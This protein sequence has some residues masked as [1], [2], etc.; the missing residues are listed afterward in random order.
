VWRMPTIKVQIQSADENLKNFCRI[1]A[2]PQCRVKWATYSYVSPEESSPKELRD[3]SSSDFTIVGE[4]EEYRLVWLVDFFE[5]LK[6]STMGQELIVQGIAYKDWR[7][8]G[9]ENEGFEL[10]KSGKADFIL[11]YVKSGR[12]S[13]G[14]PWGYI[15]WFCKYNKEKRHCITSENAPRAEVY[16]LS[17]NEVRVEFKLLVF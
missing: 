13:E 12:I 3:L 8:I 6:R 11:T 10:F 17:P 9:E 1:N 7:S 14:K 5:K 4:I 2:E 15:V 16:F